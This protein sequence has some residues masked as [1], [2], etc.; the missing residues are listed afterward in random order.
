MSK[1]KLVLPK[2]NNNKD[3]DS[4][5]SSQLEYYDNNKMLNIVRLKKP[6]SSPIP[7]PKSSPIP[8]YITV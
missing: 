1:K 8:K 3:V 5:F 7:I 6:K 4:F 2:P